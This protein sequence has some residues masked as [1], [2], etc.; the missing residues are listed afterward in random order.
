M[1]SEAG[2]KREFLGTCKTRPQRISVWGEMV[3]LVYVG[4][5]KWSKKIFSY[6]LFVPA[7]EA[8]LIQMSPGCIEIICSSRYIN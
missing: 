1:Y 2:N 8:V 4:Q 7:S 6:S 3:K 5:H